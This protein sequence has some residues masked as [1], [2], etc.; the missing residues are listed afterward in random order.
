M[1]LHIIARNDTII[2][3]N[4]YSLRVLLQDRHRFLCALDLRHLINPLSLNHM[5]I[6]TAT[7]CQSYLNDVTLDR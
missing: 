5:G 3:P 2:A 4:Y 7:L 1:R 6:C